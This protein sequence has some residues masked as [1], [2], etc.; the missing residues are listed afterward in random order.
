M[1]LQQKCKV[2]PLYRIYNLCGREAINSTKQG[3]SWEADSA[4]IMKKSLP[5][6]E[7]EGSL[8]YSQKP[9]TGHCPKPHESS[10]HPQILFY[11]GPC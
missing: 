11:C 9:P 5:S 4:Q 2:Y 3:I 7:H 1:Y 6:M 8:P 10:P